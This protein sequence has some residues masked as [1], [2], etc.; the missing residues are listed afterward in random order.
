MMEK[1][2]FTPTEDDLRSAYKMHFRRPRGMQLVAMIATGLA[3]SVVLSAMDGFSDGS[4]ALNLMIVMII[5]ATL[6]TAIIFLVIQL[7]WIPRLSKKLFSQQKDL[8]LQTEIWWDDDKFY[9][10]NEQGEA[11]LR[12][13]DLVKWQANEKV[14]L[15]YRSDQ[16]FNFL[17]VRIFRS[18][19]HADGIIRK[20]QNA[21]VPGERK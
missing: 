16:L 1:L 4:K 17:P 20:L 5:W 19:A 9:S 13:A 10:K 6:I 15:L 8:H 11:H 7:W 12:F 21:R 2:V 18:Y 14:I 3:I